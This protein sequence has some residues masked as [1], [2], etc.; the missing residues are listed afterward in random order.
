M[1]GKPTKHSQSASTVAHMALSTTVPTG[2]HAGIVL[3]EPS[4][5]RLVASAWNAQLGFTHPTAKIVSRVIQG[6]N[7]ISVWQPLIAAIAMCRG[8]TTLDTAPA[9]ENAFHVGMA[10]GLC[11]TIQPASR[12]RQ[13]RASRPQAGVSASKV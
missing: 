12:A 3:Q 1:D 13:A 5:M 7:L 6:R 11:Q 10:A 4:P 2:H 8:I 9:A